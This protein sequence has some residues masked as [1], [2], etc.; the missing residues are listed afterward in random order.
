MSGVISFTCDHPVNMKP[1]WY[2]A[3]G[4]LPQGTVIFNHDQSGD[5]YT[6]PVRKRFGVQRFIMTVGKI[7]FLTTLFESV[8]GTLD[9]MGSSP[10]STSRHKIRPRS[11]MSKLEWHPQC[12]DLR[13]CASGGSCQRDLPNPSI[14]M[15][16]RENVPPAS[17]KNRNPDL[18]TIASGSPSGRQL[19]CAHLP[20]HSLRAAP[21]KCII[22]HSLGSVNLKRNEK[23]I[24]LASAQVSRNHRAQRQGKKRAYTQAAL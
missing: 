20:N 23:A 5:N 2:C 24:S 16:C 8:T 1:H 17:K 21:A 14:R 7:S 6:E 13:P 11:I 3:Q 10:S 19:P 9:W 4:I 22:T 12:G 18:L 15:Q